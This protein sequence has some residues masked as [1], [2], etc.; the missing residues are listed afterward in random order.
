MQLR[1]PDA[2]QRA[3]KGRDVSPHWLRISLLR[4]S[5]TLKS[6]FGA[7]MAGGGMGGAT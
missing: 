4:F 1:C 7:D 2:Q 5:D 6:V 3:V